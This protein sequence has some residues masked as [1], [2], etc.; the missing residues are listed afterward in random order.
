[1]FQSLKN[2]LK[3]S[4][5]TLNVEMLMLYVVVVLLEE[6]KDG[7]LSRLLTE[8]GFHAYPLSAQASSSWEDFILVIDS[9]LAMHAV[10]ILVLS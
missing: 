4:L 5:A 7:L 8:M 1:M 9:L 3:V 10:T 2:Y 6:Q